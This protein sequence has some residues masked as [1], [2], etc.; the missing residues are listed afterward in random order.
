[1]SHSHIVSLCAWPTV[2]ISHCRNVSLTPCLIISSYLRLS[3]YCPHFSFSPCL[4]DFMTSH[5]LHPSLFP[6]FTVSKLI[7]FVSR[8]HCLY[9]LLIVFMM[10]QSLTASLSRSLTDSRTHRLQYMYH[11]LH[12]S[13]YFTVSISNCSNVSV[14]SCPKESMSHHFHVLFIPCLPVSMSYFLCILLYSGWCLTVS[15]CL[16]IS[17]S[18]IIHFSLS[19]C[20]SHCLDVSQSRCHSVSILHC[21]YASLLPCL[22]VTI[23][24]YLHV[25]QSPCLTVS[26]P[27]SLLVSSSIC[28]TVPM[29]HSLRVSQSSNLTVSV[30]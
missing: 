3:S 7:L 9:V 22:T 24:Y 19:P 29:S 6:C 26:M 23:S 30:S 12:I 2:S 11:C 28:L 27:H 5:S 17:K 13:L 8:S 16:A 1:M 21:L 4:T 25:T 20:L 10:S 15:I 14:D 18:R